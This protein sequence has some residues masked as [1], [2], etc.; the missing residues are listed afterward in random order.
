M[1]TKEL[2][3]T[4]RETL[5]ELD[6]LEKQL[7]RVGSDGHPAGYK[8]T[9]PG[10]IPGTNDPAAAAAQLADGLEALAQ[11]KREE[12]TRLSE[13]IYALLSTITNHRV[14]MVVQRYYMMAETDASISA[15]MNISR[16][17]VNQ[18][19]KDFVSA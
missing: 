16:G 12:L 14:F 8:A 1:T 15:V 3:E 18:I 13:P 19:R 9:R 11:R 2:L 4:Y 17:R 6:E 10:Q 7:A 5:L